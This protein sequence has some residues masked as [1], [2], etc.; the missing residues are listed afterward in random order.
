MW[1][2]G[3]E[4]NL[5]WFQ[6][7][8]SLQV[9]LYSEKR[10]LGN[11]KNTAF[12]VTKYTSCDSVSKCLCWPE[13]QLLVCE[14][15]VTSTYCWG[16]YAQIKIISREQS[17]NTNL[18]SK[19]IKGRILKWVKKS[20]IGNLLVTTLLYLN[21][22]YTHWQ[23]PDLA[24]EVLW[25]KNFKPWGGRKAEWHSVN[26]GNL[27]TARSGELHTHMG[28]IPRWLVFSQA[29]GWHRVE[30]GTCVFPFWLNIMK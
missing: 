18:I 15:S 25:S 8:C 12:Q 21:A 11:G 4:T 1:I 16:Q 30:K 17:I 27:G 6:N 19:R 24:H 9:L 10:R 7:V 5:I 13:S 23:V 22:C 3:F 29:G 20:K 2:L 14:I 26:C 28:T